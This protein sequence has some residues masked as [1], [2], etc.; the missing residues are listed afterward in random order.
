MSKVYT[1]IEKGMGSDKGSRLYAD[2]KVRAKIK[3]LEK[4]L[5][6]RHVRSINAL[7]EPTHMEAVK[8]I[9]R[10]ILEGKV[11]LFEKSTAISI[12]FHSKMNAKKRAAG[13]ISY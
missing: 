5:D 4:Q 6:H 3:E 9:D 13:L 11:S 7:V 1:V 2:P 10:K 8:E 12:L